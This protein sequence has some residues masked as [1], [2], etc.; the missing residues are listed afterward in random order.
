MNRQLGQTAYRN[1]NYIQGNT[2]KSAQSAPDI[3]RRRVH[4]ESR[5]KNVSAETKRNRERE[6]VMNLG[7]VL[8]LSVAAIIMFAVCIEYLQM[9]VNVT[10]RTNNIASLEGD[11]QD[12]TAENDELE[13]KL[14]TSVNLEQ[15]KKVAMEELGM[16][17]PTQEQIV[18][19]EDSNSD[20]INQYENIPDKT[21]ASITNVLD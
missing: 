2:V 5:R 17:Y 13:N 9:K 6:T 7:Y 14:N 3:K 18:T 21:S 15:I 8:F 20:Y 11:L 10:N 16:V 4:E 1:A 19:Y 12:L